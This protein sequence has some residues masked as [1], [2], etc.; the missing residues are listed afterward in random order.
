[1]LP[2]VFTQSFFVSTTSLLYLMSPVISGQTT[3]GD[4]TSTSTLSASAS[5][6]SYTFDSSIITP[7]G[8][9]TYEG[10]YNEISTAQRALTGPPMINAPVTVESCAAFCNGYT[11][12]GVEDGD[13]CYCG[14][15][16]YPGSQLVPDQSECYQCCAGDLTQRCG[17]YFRLGIYEF[18]GPPFS[19]PP[20][21]GIVTYNGP[22]T[23]IPVTTLSTMVTTTS[24]GSTITMTHTGVSTSTYYGPVTTGIS[25]STWVSTST[26]LTT[27]GSVTYTATSIVPETSTIPLCDGGNCMTNAHTPGGSPTM[28]TVATPAGASSV[29]SPTAETPTAETAIAE[30]TSVGACTRRKRVKRG[31]EIIWEG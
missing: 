5:Q 17:G 28:H 25:Y 11:Y 26:G 27:S 20:Y 16:I 9:Y 29:E 30:T 13:E 4:T 19:A 22:A 12:F 21:T 2:T 8:D 1:M 6:Y 18:N 10:C 24:G 31:E 23:G 3:T 14:N 7:V 15:D